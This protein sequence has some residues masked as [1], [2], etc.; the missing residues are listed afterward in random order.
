MATS[1]RCP[2]TAVLC[3]LVT[4][5]TLLCF[6]SA[7]LAAAPASPSAE[8]YL[9]LAQAAYAKGD[10]AA[11]YANANKAVELKPDWGEA[12][13]YRGLAQ[14][15]Q[16][17]F[18]AGRTDLIAARQHSP[19]LATRINEETRVVLQRRA[20]AAKAEPAKPNRPMAEERAR[21]AAN[22]VAKNEQPAIALKLYSEA[23]NFDRSY[24]AAY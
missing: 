7:M 9:K 16:G 13:M 1:T 3:R 8:E 6:L 20:E 14:L 5:V 22:S 2:M 11:V 4:S 10:L 17:E 21:M 18:I 19:E 15:G 24:A 23:I 12:L